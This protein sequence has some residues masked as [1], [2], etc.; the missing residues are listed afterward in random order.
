MPELSAKEKRAAENDA[1]NAA[2]EAAQTERRAVRKISH[3]RT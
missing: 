3:K 1:R 2:A